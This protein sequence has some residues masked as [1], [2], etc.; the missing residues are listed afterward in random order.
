MEKFGFT[1]F[2]GVLLSFMFL[3]SFAEW[4]WNKRV[5]ENLSHAEAEA[6]LQ[7][8][9]ENYKLAAEIYDN[10]FNEVIEKPYI[11]PISKED[12]DRL[13]SAKGYRIL[14]NPFTG[15]DRDSEHSGIDLVGTWHSRVVAVADGEVIDHYHPPDRKWHGHPVLGGMIRIQHNDGRISVYGHLSS[16]YVNETTKRFVKQGQII[17]RT[18]ET[19]MAYGEHLHF[20]LWENGELLNPLKYIDVAKEIR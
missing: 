1:L 18:G 3:G 15:G 20:E 7:K 8:D 19:G 11:N 17:G 9:I 14:H 2:I 5:E 16:T 12:Y 13:T 6:S 10:F 4:V